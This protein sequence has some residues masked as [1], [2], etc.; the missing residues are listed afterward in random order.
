[1][2][3]DTLCWT[4]LQPKGAAPVA[5]GGHTTTL[6]GSKLWVFGGETNDRRLLNDV[7]TLDLVVRRR[8]GP[9]AERIQK[10]PIK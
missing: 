1:M 2:D 9:F 8:P 6:I 7:H 10:L 4:K 3:L 5:R